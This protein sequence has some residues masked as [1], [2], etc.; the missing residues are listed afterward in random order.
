MAVSEN[1]EHIKVPL[2][3]YDYLKKDIHYYRDA[4]LKKSNA[5]E[6][7]IQRASQP[8]TLSPLGGDCSL[9]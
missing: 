7:R 4:N 3:N 6:T 5:G 2:L 9:V 8:I 1:C